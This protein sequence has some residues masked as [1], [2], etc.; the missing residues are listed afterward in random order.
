MIEKDDYSS[1]IQIELDYEKSLKLIQSEL[2]ISDEIIDNFAT[3]K[4]IASI[5]SITLIMEEHSAKSSTFLLEL[6]F[7]LSKLLN[8]FNQKNIRVRMELY[9]MFLTIC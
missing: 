3:K 7:C 5:S 1:D 9:K 8:E 4:K 2:N 6:M